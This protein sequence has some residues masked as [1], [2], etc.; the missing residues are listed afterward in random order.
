M[1]SIIGDDVRS[2]ID[3]TESN[4]LALVPIQGINFFFIEEDRIALR[5]HLFLILFTGKNFRL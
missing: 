2:L 1:L 5:Y 3:F 4:N